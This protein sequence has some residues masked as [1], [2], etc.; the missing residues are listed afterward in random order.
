MSTEKGTIFAFVV[1]AVVILLVIKIVRQTLT[2]LYPS[3]DQLLSK[4]IEYGGEGGDGGGGG[5]CI[6][7]C[8]RSF[9]IVSER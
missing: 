3:Q 2:E 8:I 5:S 6:K 1:P 7:H 9:E 4:I